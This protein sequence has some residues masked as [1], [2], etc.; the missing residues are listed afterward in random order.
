MLYFPIQGHDPLFRS[1]ST[2]QMCLCP[3]PRKKLSSLIVWTYPGGAL[4][5]PNGNNC[6]RF[7]LV[8]PLVW[9]P[10]GDE[11]SM[12]CSPNQEREFFV[13]TEVGKESSLQSTDLYYRLRISTL[14]CSLP[15]ELTDLSFRPFASISIPYSF[16]FLS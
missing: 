11:R 4:N 15:M 13:R 12:V 6:L 3:L 9:L 2:V 16:R 5:H 10:K 8:S 14:D 1:G 7:K